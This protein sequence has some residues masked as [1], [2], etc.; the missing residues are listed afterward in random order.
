MSNPSPCHDLH[1]LA[2][3]SRPHHRR[4]SQ[5]HD[6]SH[7]I[8][9]SPDSMPCVEIAPQQLPF[10]FPHER[11]AHAPLHLV[12]FVDRPSVVCAPRGRPHPFAER[13]LVDNLQHVQVD[14][15]HLPEL[16][17]HVRRHGVWLLATAR[18]EPAAQGTISPDFQSGWESRELAQGAVYVLHHAGGRVPAHRHHCQG[19]VHEFRR[20][21]VQPQSSSSRRQREAQPRQ[22][23][24]GKAEEVEGALHVLTAEQ[25]DLPV[26][27]HQDVP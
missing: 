8:R 27:Q 10:R 3:A 7:R 2:S 18:D 19:N 24:V 5:L 20:V 25:D 26:L 16:E 1:P 21:A 12:E 4:Q 15:V 23:A 22:P 13:C 6:A 11:L 14:E 9:G 17:Q